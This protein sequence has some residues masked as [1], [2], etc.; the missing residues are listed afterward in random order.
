LEG[1]GFTALVMAGGT[2]PT[3]TGWLI[4]VFVDDISG[5]VSALPAALRALTSCALMAAPGAR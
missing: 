2:D 5:D 3:G 1:G 4:E